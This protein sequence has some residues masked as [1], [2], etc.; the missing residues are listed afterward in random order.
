[1][2]NVSSRQISRCL[3]AARLGLAKTSHD[4]TKLLQFNGFLKFKMRFGLAES[5]AGWS[6]SSQKSLKIVF[7]TFFV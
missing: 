2:F 7:R 3:T 4:L 6:S 1:V 5:Q